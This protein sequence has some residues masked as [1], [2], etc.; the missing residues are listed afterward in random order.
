MKND[1]T[2][3]LGSYDPDFENYKSGESNIEE[4]EE[5]TQKMSR[6]MYFVTIKRAYTLKV[7]HNAQLKMELDRLR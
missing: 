3:F 2:Y 5:M 6:G 4:R 1:C 7:I